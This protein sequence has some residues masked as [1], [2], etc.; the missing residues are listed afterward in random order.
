MSLV[1]LPED[2]LLLILPYLHVR[3][4]SSLCRI[5]KYFYKTFNDA[6]SYWRYHATAC[7]HLPQHFQ[8]KF[9][10]FPWRLMCGIYHKRAKLFIWGCPRRAGSNSSEVQVGHLRWPT[11]IPADVGT[12]IEIHC[13][14]DMYGHL[15]PF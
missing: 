14:Y 5:N 10:G 15:N 6:P 2:I 3:D 11:Q 1:Y 7:L 12:I 8:D 13:A 9:D 4:F